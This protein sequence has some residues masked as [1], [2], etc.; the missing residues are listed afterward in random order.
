MCRVKAATVEVICTANA[1]VGECPVYDRVDNV[2]YWV[3]I[4]APTLN[5]LDLSTGTNVAQVMPATIGSFALRRDGGF[6]LALKAGFA[7]LDRFGGDPV[8]LDDP[9]RHLPGNRFNDGRCDSRGR[10]WVGTMH[11][12]ESGIAPSASLYCRDSEGNTS[13]RLGGLFVSNGLAFSPDNRTAYLADSHP[14]VRR[15][16]AFDFDLDDGMLSNRRVFVDTAGTAGRPDGAAI[17]VDGC[18]WSASADAGEVIRYT[19]AGTIDRRIALPVAKPTMPAFGGRDLR[20]LFVTS[21]RPPQ[22]DPREPLAGAIFAIDVG[23]S[24]LEEPRFAG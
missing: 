17:D 22:P 12:P 16:W 18:Y 14:D 23:I 3:D 15:I 10:F 21:I 5:R 8:M 7:S 20:T 24:G 19:P 1:R 11:S 9:E 13:R 4:L 2:L 6:L